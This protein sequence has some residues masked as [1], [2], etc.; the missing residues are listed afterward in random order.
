MFYVTLLFYVETT[1][2]L[3]EQRTEFPVTWYTFIIYF[4]LS[5]QH[6]NDLLDESA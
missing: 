4:Y 5:K 6:R 1:A 2:V 3:S